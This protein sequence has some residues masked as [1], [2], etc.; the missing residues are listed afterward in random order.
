MSY[1]PVQVSELRAGEKYCGFRVE[2]TGEIPR[3]NATYAKLVHEASGAT[4]YYSDRDDG[5]LMFSIGFRTLPEDDT[6]VFHILEHS[7]L[8]GSKHFPL[9]EPFVNLL[10]T[11]MAVDLNAM[12]YQDRTV[13]YF[14]T[15]D[16]QDYLNMMTVY[17]DAVFEPLLLTDRRIFEKEAWHLAPDGE[18]GV[19]CSGVV[20]NEMQGHE[21]N[22]DYILWQTATRQLYPERFDRFNSGGDPAAIRTLTYES[23]CETYRRFYGSDNAVIYLSG[24][25][26]AE[27]L[28]YLDGVLTKRPSMGYAPPA[29]PQSHPP[30][31]SPDG[32]A[33]YEL[34]DKEETEGN[35][36]LLLSFV[37]PQA[38]KDGQILALSLLSRYLAETTE[39][40]LS[41]AVLSSGVGQDFAMGV[42]ADTREGLVW[43]SLNRSDPQQAERFRE[44]IL[45]T[46]RDMAEKGFD[47]DRLTALIDSHETDCRRAAIRTATGFRLMESFMR[48]HVLTGDAFPEDGLT[49]LRT[50]LEKNPHLFE[51]VVK[52]GLLESAHWALTRCIPSRTASAERGEVTQ[53]WLADKAKEISATEGG[54]ESLTAAAEALDAYLLA[55]DDPTD[56]AKIPRLTSADISL[57]APE[58][59]VEE[60]TV[61]VG[62]EPCVS[63]QYETNAEGMTMAGL[64]F[65]V[66]GLDGEEL[67]YL[68]CLKQT[69]LELPTG[70]HTV[71]ELTDQLTRLHTNLGTVFVQ[72]VKDPSAEGFAHYLELRVD[73]P[74]EKLSDAMSLLGEYLSDIVFD[75][76]VL[77]RLLSSCAGMRNRLISSG[78]A[79][80]VAMAERCLTY[81]GAVRWELTGEPAYA[82]MA[83]LAQ[84][85]DQRADALIQGMER[86]Y[87]RLLAGVKPLCFHVGSKASYD[88]WRKGLERLPLH[89]CCVDTA[90]VLT[91][92]PKTHA[93]LT[94]PGGVN[95]CAR[96]ADVAAVGGVYTP[97]W[98]VVA[99]Y[100]YSSYFWDEIRAKGGAYGGACTVYPYGLVAMT[101]YRDPH[102]AE[103][104]EVFERLPAWMKNHLPT[105]GEVD[106]LIVSTLGQ[107]YMTPQSPIDKGMSAL[108]RYLH[109]RTA[110][111][112]RRDME[113]ILQVTPEDFAAFGDLLARLGDEGHGVCAALGG[114]APVNASN[115]F[116]TVESL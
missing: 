90:C 109:G 23:F 97:K 75:R 29:V 112:R 59:D 101:S 1:T 102:V 96:V 27:A 93:A 115:L 45:S 7:C 15:T 92:T 85:F 41:D 44:V 40:P 94:I 46:L 30:V 25:I 68:R 39:A 78:S 91:P 113:E 74:E 12:T 16:A 53:A 14:M 104:F 84:D 47:R 73:A 111:D 20:Y 95:Y 52:E 60:H 48:C 31:V 72:T 79:T 57:P 83:R 50:A 82:R 34:S 9:R 35:T 98:T 103:T 18:G 69:L 10:K 2:R 51:D 21:D 66:G 37:L 114:E 65:D 22:P 107:N 77:K 28:S 55:E 67:F 99:S 42:D 116:D 54:M 6:G 19:T 32:V 61:T 86:V 71:E 89:P 13:Y 70:K 11:S 100:L 81:A 38:Y 26:P 58:R 63:L 33:Y 17:L 24:G 110:Q 87:R 56:V 76:E 88:A 8:D 43:F 106:S 49:Q 3:M 5:Q 64:L 108:H 36:R 80:A 4:L 105:D 62:G